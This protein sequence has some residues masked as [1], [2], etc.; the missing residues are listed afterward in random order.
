ML[1]KWNWLST[2]FNILLKK[3][4]KSSMFFFLLFSHA[5][6]K[7]YEEKKLGGG[8]AGKG[9]DIKGKVPGLFY[10]MHYSKHPP[11]N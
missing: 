7:Q 2:L 5:S 10:L 4:T 8:G 3:A 9:G 11:P 6:D 1:Q